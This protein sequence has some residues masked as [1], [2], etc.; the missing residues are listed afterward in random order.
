MVRRLWSA[1]AI[2]LRVRPKRHDV[3]GAQV[4]GLRYAAARSKFGSKSNTLPE[5]NIRRRARGAAIGSGSTC[6]RQRLH[7]RR[8]AFRRSRRQ[9]R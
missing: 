5:R 4:P 7:L 6:M 8:S 1:P 2:P 9:T 3:S